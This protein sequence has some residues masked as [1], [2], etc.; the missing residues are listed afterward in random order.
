MSIRR[1]ADANLSP[2]LGILFFIPGLNYL[3]MLGLSIAPTSAAS[4]WSA[5]NKFEN[6]KVMSPLLLSIIFAVCGTAL[7]WFSTNFLKTYA[8]SLFLGSPLIVGLVQG[9]LMNRKTRQTFNRTAGHVTLTILL[10][11][12]FM[13]LF[14]LE[15]IICLAMS[16]PLS[17]VLAIIGSVFG[18][19]I[20]GYGKPSSLAPTFLLLILPMMSLTEAHSGLRPHEDYVLSAIEINA[21]PEKVWPNVVQ[22]SDLPP[23]SDWLFKLGVAYPLRAKISGTGVG[24][25]RRC[26]FST[27]DFVEPITVWD[28]P[29]TLGFGVEYQPQPMKELTFFDHVNAPHLN[30]YFRSVRGEFRLISMADG[31]TKLEG[32]TW[33]EMDIHPGWYWQ[34]YGRWF[35]HKIHMRVLDHIKNE[36][37]T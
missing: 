18:A 26:Q 11:H 21:P 13:V 15:G 2:W 28:E 24:A 14:A 33:Y 16:F 5:Q 3:L 37:E 1:A 8:A 19:G 34:I 22:F 31:K 29:R 4:T 7:V 6:E 9:F 20:A 27:G 23:T 10:I 12:L 25:I 35:I 17:V 30:G 32:R 36:T